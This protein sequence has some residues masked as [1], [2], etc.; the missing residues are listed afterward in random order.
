MS[1]FSDLEVKQ[2][3]ESGALNEFYRALGHFE[4]SLEIIKSFGKEFHIVALMVFL[5]LPFHLYFADPTLDR[6]YITIFAASV[7]IFICVIGYIVCRV[8]FVRI[9]RQ[10]QLF[11]TEINEKNHSKHPPVRWGDVIFW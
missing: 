1:G 3:A 4:R 11:V 2:F 8:V 9:S 6:Y 5:F 7:I 10:R